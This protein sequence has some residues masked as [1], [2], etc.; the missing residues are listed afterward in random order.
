M[1]LLPGFPDDNIW[2]NPSVTLGPGCRHSCRVDTERFRASRVTFHS[3]DHF[4]PVPRLPA[5]DNCGPVLHF[6]SLSFQEWR[7]QGTLCV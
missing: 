7:I 4:P 1:H 6:V 2:P 3:H 5:P